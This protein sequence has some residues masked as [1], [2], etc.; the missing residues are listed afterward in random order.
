MARPTTAVRTARARCSNSPRRE[1][2]RPSIALLASARR[3]VVPPPR[4]SQGSDGN[5]Y[6][7]TQIGGPA[8]DGTIYRMALGGGATGPVGTTPVVTLTASTPTV[9]SWT[10]AAPA[11]LP[12][13]FPPPRAARSSLPTRSRAARSNGTDYVALSGKVKIKAGKTSKS[14]QVVPQG[15]LGGAAKQNGAAQDHPQNRLHRGDDGQGEG[16]DRPVSSRLC[17]RRT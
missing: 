13:P 6:G 1:W 5:F 9:P 11:S 15:D 10:A 14:I 4:W 2:S 8:N 16:E 3:A 12:S 7:T 17:S